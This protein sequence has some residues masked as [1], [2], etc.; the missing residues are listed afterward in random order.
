M[1]ILGYILLVVIFISDLLNYSLINLLFLIVIAMLMFR[2]RAL[3]E[4]VK[5]LESI[6]R[7]L[8]K[9]TTVESKIPITTA[10][11]A[12]IVAT[13]I[14][15]QAQVVKKITQPYTQQPSVAKPSVLT[16]EK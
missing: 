3:S 2:L 14:D 12:K 4:D 16:Q 7:G 6:I 11:T 13:T 5:N 10:D 9:S 8:K 15:L 1:N